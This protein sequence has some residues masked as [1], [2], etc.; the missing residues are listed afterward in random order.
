MLKIKK[1]LV[2]LVILVTGLSACQKDTD[3]SP[4]E[5]ASIDEQKINQFIAEKALTT[6]RHSSG[7]HYI[8][9]EPGS[10]SIIYNGNTNVTVKYTGRLLDGTIFESNAIS[11]KLGGLIAGWQIGVQLVQK[12][13]KIR[14][15][16]P[17]G[18]A[19]GREGIGGIPPNA[20]L[21]FDIEL[22]EVSN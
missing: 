2:C 20:V 17:S 9:T 16:I 7:L 22:L 18:L 11:Y 1:I 19:Y 3:G 6:L 5:Q 21:D 14:L 12:G 15:I 13:G 10:G 4:D 8:I